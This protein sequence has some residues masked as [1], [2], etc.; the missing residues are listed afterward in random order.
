MLFGRIGRLLAPIALLSALGPAAARAAEAKA[1]I[2]WMSEDGGRLELKLVREGLCGGILTVDSIRRQ[3]LWKG[4]PGRIGCHDGFEAG[5]DDVKRVSARGRG[6][7]ELEFKKVRARPLVVVPLPHA[8]WFSQ[9]SDPTDPIVKSALDDMIGPDGFPLPNNYAATPELRG[10]DV[11][12]E[13]RADCKMAVERILDLLSRPAAPA[14]VLRE[15][16]YGDPVDVKVADLVGA[17][18]TWFGKAVRLR[19]RLVAPTPGAPYA[20]EDGDAHLAVVPESG[21]APFVRSK[22]ESWKDGDVELV[23]VFQRVRESL[24]GTAGFAVSFWSCAPS[25]V[26]AGSAEGA[27]V[28]KATLAELF[29]NPNDWVGQTVQVVGKFRGRNLFGDLPPQTMR[30][31]GDFVI[32][33]DRY[34]LWVIGRPAGSG[35]A[36]DPRAPGDTSAWLEIVAQPV[37]R[38]HRL[39]LQARRVTLIPPPPGARV[40]PTRQLVGTDKPPVVVFSLPVEGEVVAPDGRIVIQFSKQMDEE[41]FAGRVRLRYRGGGES[42]FRVTARYDDERR[43]LVVDPGV[44]LAVGKEVEV[45]LLPGIVDVDG[46]ALEPRPGRDTA[47]AVD[48]LRYRVGGSG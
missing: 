28:R 25:S 24:A 46:L 33:D 15:T 29:A 1:P 17:P 34:A 13:V 18:A 31:G 41:S 39:V 2:A 44:L 22:V 21:L 9:Q 32:K 40:V 3:V 16:L 47:G 36:L 48:V 30:F 45:E 7:F 27:K 38:S 12:P 35:F 20:L 10:G 14:A 23:G 43:S 37:E 42:D 5:F 11:P 19:G 4:A 26:D 6:G 8:L